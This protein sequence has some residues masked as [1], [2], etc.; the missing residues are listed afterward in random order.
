MRSVAVIVFALCCCLY[1]NAKPSLVALGGVSQIDSSRHPELITLITDSLVQL[2]AEQGHHLEF[3]ELVSATSQVVSGT[4]YTASAIFK[5]G[6][7]SLG[8]FTCDVNIWEQPW[9]NFR[10]FEAKCPEQSYK[11]IKGTQAS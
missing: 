10:Q 5:H 7:E 8:T 2:K 3:Q 9:V 11:V 6:G 1:V 4:A